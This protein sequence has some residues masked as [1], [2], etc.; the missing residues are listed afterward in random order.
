MDFTEVLSLSV[1]FG[2]QNGGGG[3]KGLV[4]CSERVAWGTSRKG[5]DTPEIL[6]KLWQNISRVAFLLRV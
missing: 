4:G 5:C 3:F 1:G 2:G 6:L